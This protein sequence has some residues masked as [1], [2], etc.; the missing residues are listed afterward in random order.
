MCTRVLAVGLLFAALPV[1]AQ[2]V[3]FD[4]LNSNFDEQVFGSD[5]A[6]ARAHIQPDKEGLRFRLPGTDSPRS[7]ISIIKRFALQA[8]FTATVRY[9]IVAFEPPTKGYGVGVELYL[10]LDNPTKDGI[11]L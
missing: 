4:F 11:V 3:A 7:P 8:D 2:E 5:G 6:N 9:E 10:I 1:A